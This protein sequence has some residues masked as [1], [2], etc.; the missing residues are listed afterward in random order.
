MNGEKLN[1]ATQNMNHNQLKELK[2]LFQ[3]FVAV[4][5]DINVSTLH[6]FHTKKP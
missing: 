6:P 2:G 1:F 4:T 5:Y 3:E